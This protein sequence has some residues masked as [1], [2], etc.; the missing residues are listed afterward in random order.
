MSQRIKIGIS[1][2]LLGEEVRWN[3]QHKKDRFLVNTLGQFV[4]FVPVCPEVECGLGVPRETMRLVG[5]PE[6]PRLITRKTQVDHTARMKKWAREKLK[7]IEKEDLC[8]FVFKKNSP[9]SGLWRVKVYNEKTGQPG[10]P[11][12][13]IFAR[14]FTDRFPRVPV[15]EEGRLNDPGLREIFNEQVFTLQRMRNRRC[16]AISIPTA[17]E[18]YR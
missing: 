13:G 16:S 8:G 1:A 10:R 17:R 12:R 7:S 6:E 14:A 5:N 3:G 9:S 11:G 15:E 2:C 18:I 4:D